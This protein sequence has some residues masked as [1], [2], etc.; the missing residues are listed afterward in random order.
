MAEMAAFLRPGDASTGDDVIT[1]SS[2]LK[3]KKSKKEKKSK[4]DKK[5]K[6]KSRKD[7][8][9]RKDGANDDGDE[10]VVASEKTTT[11]ESWMGINEDVFKL[12]SGADH[13]KQKQRER[14]EVL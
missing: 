9:H 4:K 11:T 5:E 8:H 10:W 13:K 3:L 1:S 2:R 6:K 7:E 14:D 12:M